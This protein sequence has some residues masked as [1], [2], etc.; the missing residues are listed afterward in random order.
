MRSKSQPTLVVPTLVILR[1]DNLFVVLSLKL[2][3]EKCKTSVIY[4]TNTYVLQ[5]I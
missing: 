2:V 1:K 4:N 3:P 5:K